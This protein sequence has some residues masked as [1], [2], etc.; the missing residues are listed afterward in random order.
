MREGANGASLQFFKEHIVPLALNSQANWRKFSVEK[1]N[2]SK[3]HIY[4]LLSCQLWG[5]FPG[6]CRHPRDPE[7]LRKLAPTLGEV[8]ENNPEFRAAIYDGLIELL[9]DSQSS[10]CHAA[11][12]QY[13]R[14]FLPRLFNIYTQ[15]PTGTYEADQR[16]RALDVIRLYIAR[17]PADVQAQLFE[18]AQELLA[19]SAVASFEYDAYFDINA[20]IVRVQKCR[21]IEAYFEKYMAPVLRND[22]S[23]LV[24]RDEQKFKKQQRK[25]YE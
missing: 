7:Y 5:L 8:L 16:K 17:A 3:A 6:F 2:N 24:S 18:N 10:E 13:A 15:K 14:N 21:G 25:T 22:K 9:D 20:A 23:K 1:K 4:E 19:A 12:G 11:I